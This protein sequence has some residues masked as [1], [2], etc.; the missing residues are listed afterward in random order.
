MMAV[1][2]W[3]GRQKL[4]QEHPPGDKQVIEFFNPFGTS[5]VNF[6]L[7]AEDHANGKYTIG[8]TNIV[9]P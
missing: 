9:L 7:W 5:G 6:T 2:P 4:S 1:R 3:T 8:L